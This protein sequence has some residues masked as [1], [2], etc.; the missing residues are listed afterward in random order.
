M[1][2]KSWNLSISLTDLFPQRKVRWSSSSLI[3]NITVI[4]SI[5]DHPELPARETESAWDGDWCAA[6]RDPDGKTNQ[7]STI[8]VKQDEQVRD[9]RQRRLKP[10][11]PTKPSTLSFRFNL[12]IGIIIIIHY[13][14]L[15][16]LP[17]QH[18][19]FYRL[20][21]GSRQADRRGWSPP[22]FWSLFCH[23]FKI[24]WHILT[25]FTIL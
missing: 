2:K 21:K 8:F 19:N 13:H 23:F 20:H 24:S 17:P 25:Y 16:H 7:P 10:I 15:H 18:L 22:P 5:N 9:D 1:Q 12:I 3:I 11:T 6:S 4:I 14:Y